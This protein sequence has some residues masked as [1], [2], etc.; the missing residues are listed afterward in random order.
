MS[1]RV[2]GRIGLACGLILACLGLSQPLPSSA[3]SV[4]GS[5]TISATVAAVRLIDIDSSGKIIQIIT[6]TPLA[7]EPI[8]IANYVYAS[9][10]PL[11]RR[12]AIQYQA[13]VKH[14][15]PDRIGVIYKYSPI[16][17]KKHL[18]LGRIKHLAAYQS[19]LY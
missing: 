13:I 8:V 1:R 18:L 10:I 3:Q 7:V 2:W 4:S 16:N 9:P 14:L 6:N 19:V 11:S 15:K 17:Q 12:V 5:V